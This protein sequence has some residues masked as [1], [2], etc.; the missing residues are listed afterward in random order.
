MLRSLL[1]SDIAWT[2][3]VN[4][5]AFIVRLH[6]CNLPTLS[7]LTRSLAF[8]Y[9][10]VLVRRGYH[11]IITVAWNSLRLWENS[12]KNMFFIDDLTNFGKQSLKTIPR[13]SFH[14][15]PIVGNYPLNKFVMFSIVCTSTTKYSLFAVCCV[16]KWLA[17]STF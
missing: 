1:D 11:C 6:Q 3:W 8:Y 13:L 5:E 7:V 2:L 12:L 14:Y 15:L 9:Q 17:G 4:Y 10:I 16:G